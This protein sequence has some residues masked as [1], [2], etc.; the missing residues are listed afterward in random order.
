MVLTKEGSEE[1][2]NTAG[3]RSNTRGTSTLQCSKEA[4]IQC[5]G[6]ERPRDSD[7]RGREG[8]ELDAR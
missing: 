1:I 7:V 3:R 8:E 5:G 6:G 4:C 2:Q